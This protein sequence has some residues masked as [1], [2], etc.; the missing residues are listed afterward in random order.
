MSDETI[1]SKIQMHHMLV[2]DQESQETGEKRKSNT[3]SH[4]NLFLIEIRVSN[5]SGRNK[6]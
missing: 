6:L 3:P 1:R 5:E 4:D 2:G